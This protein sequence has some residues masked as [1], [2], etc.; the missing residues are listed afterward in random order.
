MIKF[1]VCPHDTEK[2]LGRWRE[3]ALR[4]SRL[5]GE[6]VVFEVLRGHR[7]EYEKIERGEFFDLYY[8]GPLVSPRLYELGYLPVAKFKGQRDKLFLLVRDRIPEEGNILVATPFLRP[9]GYSLLSLDIERVRIV[10]TEDF[11][12]AFE[13]LKRGQVHA[14]LMYNDTWEQIE[15]EDKAP[16]RVVEDYVFETSHLFMSKPHVYHKVK[17]ALLSI[18]ELEP[19]GEED[20]QRV[21][22]LFREFDKFMKLW[23][24]ASFF[25]TLDRAKHVAVLLYTHKIE[26]VNRSFS[27]LVGYP[28]ENLIGMDI[29]EAIDRIIHPKHRELT[30]EVVKRRLRGEH[31]S[32][33]YEELPLLKR[34]G[35]IAWTIASSETVLYEGFYADVVY[36]VDIT[37]RKRL[38]NLYRLLIGI[39][40]QILKAKTEKD[41]LNKICVQV[42][43]SLGLP[44]AWVGV[45][46]MEKEV[47][48]PLYSYGRAVDY[49]KD[50]FIST[51]E[52]LPEGQGVTA[53]AYR[54]NRIHINENTLENPMMTP[55]RERQISMGILSSCAIPIERDGEVKYVIN[56]YAEEPYFFSEEN[57]EVLEEI[58]QDVEFV[59]KRLE[60]ENKNLVIASA[61]ENSNSW[62]LITDEKGSIL[63][64]N[65]AVSELSGYSREELIGKN[66][67]IF[68][69]GYHTSEFYREL[70]D[71]ILSGEVFNA[72]FVNKA[73]DG[74]LIYLESSIYPVRLPDGSL[75]FM[76][77]GKDI[78]REVYL[79][80][81][82]ERLT[83]YDTL[84]GILN[85]DGMRIRANELLKKSQMAVLVLVDIYNFSMINKVY[86]EAVGDR[87]LVETA[88]RLLE[89]FGDRGMV[90]RTAGD[91]F[92]LL[93]PVEK[94][95][96]ILELLEVLEEFLGRP[97]LINGDILTPTFNMGISVYPSDGATFGE[98]R[99]K[100]GIAL[101]S[102]KAGGEGE[103]RFFE[104]NFEER[105]RTTNLAIRL[106][107]RAVEE[108]L[109]VLYY[110]PYWKSKDIALAG[111]E[112]LIRIVD[113]EGK[114]YTPVHFIDYLENSKYLKSFE[115]FLL[116]SARD[117]YQRYRMPLSINISAR[118]FKDGKFIDMLVQQLEGCDITVE[119]TERVFMVEKEKALKHIDILKTAGIKIALD[120]FGTGYSSL[121]YLSEIPVDVVKI[122]ISF[123]RE[124][125][126]NKKIKALVRNVI[127]LARDLGIQTLAEG[128]ETTQQLEILQE[129]GCTY[130]QG[131]LLGKPMPEEEA[132]KL[133]P[134]V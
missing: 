100:A 127:N 18:D 98:L 110:Q 9:A 124:L 121:S 102:A 20:I 84:T 90:G 76:E 114:V 133:I 40:Q 56:L 15:E 128:V 103:R 82:V 91:E 37:K 131:Y 58:K 130:V 97:I 3:L 45:P 60:E 24:K 112:A 1:S 95:E 29:F 75:R 36:F 129:M 106:V 73:K 52:D 8:A 93:L 7:E 26:Y 39:N 116:R 28:Q 79:S 41:L 72:L 89:V 69:S 115:A 4:L 109:F 32:Q 71:T 53:R 126:T 81:E 65:K 99:E 111:F 122:D 22:K 88:K 38:K 85:I 27:E 34:D 74:R 10:L 123:V 63:Y 59:L 43:E 61:L 54:E 48:S 21:V 118:S 67:R 19:A 64:V 120:D 107:Q 113:K 13:L 62:V 35:T 87:V 49:L 83:F 68:K 104:T 70:W 47:I 132:I 14:C 134:M 51:R 117:F 11:I 46:D 17:T 23:S 80:S 125:P 86:G 6:E 33:F 50:L 119:I 78:T 66:P 108:D 2:G 105:I 12:S 44:L 5:L 31:F 96:D 77:I 57:K 25:Y 94:E 16:F 30:A 55:W 42:V 92:V 101:S